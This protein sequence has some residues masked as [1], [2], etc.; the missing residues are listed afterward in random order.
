VLP[1]PATAITSA[2]AANNPKSWA[3]VRGEATASDRASSSV[4]TFTTAD[5]GLASSTARRT[6]G[7]SSSGSAAERTRTLP[8]NGACAMGRYN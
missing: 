4:S 5:S 7:I 2:S 6:A 8:A 3:A 1:I